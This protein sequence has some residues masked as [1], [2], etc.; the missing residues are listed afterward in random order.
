MKYHVKKNGLDYKICMNNTLLKIADL[1][2]MYG[3]AGNVLKGISLEV[4][5]GNI[6]A[7]LGA[8]GAGK[9]TTL[10]T[11]SGL[12]ST[13]QGRVK[14][15]SVAFYKENITGLPAETLVRKGIFHVIEGRHVFGDLTVEEN[16]RIGGYTRSDRNELNNDLTFVY[17]LFPRLLERHKQ[18][19]GFLSG[20][21]QQMLAIGRGLM[22]HPRLL[23]L[24]EPSLGLAPLLIQEIFL[25]IRRI[26]KERGTTILL[27]EQN[28]NLALATADFAY[29]IENGRI[30]LSGSAEELKNST[31][32]QEFYLGISEHGEQRNYRQLKQQIKQQYSA[33]V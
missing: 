25:L 30:A 2:V 6:V 15:G 21:E 27:V 17:D 29:I 4:P 16:L 26:N 23:L 32:V 18:P 7:L 5:E 22:A 33:V 11:I 20:G 12:L 8:N 28:A 13:E 31:Q 14:T 19:A 24:D 9:S 10:K 3:E 1:E